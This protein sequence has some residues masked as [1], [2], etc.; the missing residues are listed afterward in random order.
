MTFREFERHG[1][2]SIAYRVD[3]PATGSLGRVLLVHGY[4]EHSARYD[5]TVALWVG[6]SLTV[7]R[8]DLRG[9]GRSGGPRGH[10]QAFGQYAEDLRMLLD[11]LETEPLWRSAGH[12]PGRPVLFGHSLGGLIATHTAAELGERVAGL[13]LSSP[14]FGLALPISAP[15]RLLA[16]VAARVAP[17]LRQSSGLR[18]DEL[19]HDPE[20]AAGYDT[21]PLGFH[22]ATAGWFIEAERAQVQLLDVAP[23]LRCPVLLLAAGDDRVASTDAARRTFDRFGSVQ[24]EFEAIPGFF[25]ELL[26]EPGWRAVATRYANHMLRWS[27]T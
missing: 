18:G 27:A 7:A 20:L 17:G 22:H 13:A 9:H 23:R 10:V 2:P 25:H 15:L 3:G 24:K 16:R 4:A 26:N 12:G 1:E 8:F 19:T 6:R 21:D 14:F 5:R 11:H